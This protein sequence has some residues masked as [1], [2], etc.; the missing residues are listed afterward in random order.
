MRFSL[1]GRAQVVKDLESRERTDVG[2]F[3][4]VCQQFIAHPVIRSYSNRWVWAAH[5]LV[6]QS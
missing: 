2:S 3:G 6:G 5:G 1:H 4:N